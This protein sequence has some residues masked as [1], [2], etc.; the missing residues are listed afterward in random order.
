MMQQ[1]QKMQ[2]CMGSI[3]QSQISAFEQRSKAAE[4]RVKSLCASGKRDEAQDEAMA[5]ALEMKANPEI[6]K[7][8]EC[9]KGMGN[10]MSG[11]PYMGQGQDNADGKSSSHVCDE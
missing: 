6:Q 3:D 11:M 9:T 4:A 8:M 10:M 1:A 7:I 2:A 5:F